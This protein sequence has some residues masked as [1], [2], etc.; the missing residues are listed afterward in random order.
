MTDSHTQPSKIPSVLGSYPVARPASEAQI[1]AMFDRVAGRY[2]FLNG[3]LSALQDRR[4]R[5]TLANLVP[6]RP[7]GTLVDMATGTGDVLIA[8]AQA[9][10]EYSHFIGGDI[11][12]EMLRLAEPKAARMLPLVQKKISFKQTSATAIDLPD[13]C[14]DTV[15]ISFGLRN[16]VDKPK[17]I[18]EFHRILKPG[19][20]LLVMEFFEP[21]NS[22]IS[23]LFQFYFHHIL[24]R[25]GGLFSDRDAYTYLP[26][27]VGS[28]YREE[29]LLTAFNRQNLKP[30]RVVRFLFGSCRIVEAIKS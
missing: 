28:F 4:W 18:E 23:R 16:V 30:G 24:P 13:Q 12:E 5:K 27:S 8:C 21:T 2:D 20:T 25:I 15:T 9:H 11:S 22:F 3:L 14:A 1:A 29:E 19:G 6:S 7:G 26:Q 17:A 10:P